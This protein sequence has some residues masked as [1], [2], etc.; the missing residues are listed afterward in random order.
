LRRI[1]CTIS[2]SLIILSLGFSIGCAGKDE[3]PVIVEGGEVESSGAA[4]KTGYVLAETSEG[5]EASIIVTAMD[6]RP[7]EDDLLMF[8]ITTATEDARSLGEEDSFKITDASKETEPYD[9]TII[10]CTET[11]SGEKVYAGSY[12]DAGKK[13]L[14]VSLS[15][16][17]S[18]FIQNIKCR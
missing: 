13:L 8:I 2:L 12:C 16:S 3:L 5:E 7:S 18:D 14:I 10:I 9:P 17:D 6:K 1:F 4:E 15:G 11:E